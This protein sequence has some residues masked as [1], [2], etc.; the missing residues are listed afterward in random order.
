MKRKRM[1]ALSAGLLALGSG[2]LGTGARAATL[3]DALPA[4]ALVTLE[5][6]NAK[7]AFDRLLGVGADLGAIFGEEAE[8]QGALDGVR[9]VLAGSL[10]QEG[11]VGVFAVGQPGQPFMPQVLGVTRATGA[12][13]D[14]F[15]DLV[16]EKKGARVGNFTFHRQGSLFVGMA[17]GLVYFSS[18]K[19]LL[20]GYLGRLSGKDAPRLGTS[21]AYTV[22]TRLLGAPELSMYLNFSATAKVVR[23]QLARIRLP[24]LLSPLVDAL[25]TL[26][27]YAGGLTTTKEG[28]SAVSAQVVNREGKDT[29]LARMLTHQTTFSVQDIVPADAESVRASACAP[30]S[31]AYTARWL[32]RLDLFEPFGFLTDSQL[33]SHLERSGQYLGDECAQVTLAGGARAGLQLDDPLASLNSAVFYHRVRDRAAAV[34]HLPEY[35]ASVNQ[36]IAG[37]G[38]SLDR[39][40]K[41]EGGLPG[42]A[43]P[44]GLNTQAATD[45]ALS[46][47]GD[48]G[49]AVGSLKM[50][51]GFRGDYLVIAFRDAALQAALDPA[52]PA[53]GADPAFR[54]AGLPLTGAG[55]Q[56][57]RN[58]PDF[59][60]EE[61]SSAILGAAPPV[62]ERAEPA[63]RETPPEANLT[64]EEQAALDE[65][66]ALLAGG[67]TRSGGADAVTEQVGAVVSNLINRY[68]GMNMSK[69]LRGNVVLGKANVLYRW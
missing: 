31:G 30:E 32:T 21:P 62:T 53:L 41:E 18:D 24:R 9:E 51:Y 22:P 14:V 60:P 38:A 66:D 43:L 39:L 47:L 69:S 1:G 7:G 45:A 63:P 68:D 46:G 59:S 4:G 33:A 17:Q 36:A 15:A 13:A 61:F 56:F 26:G 20:M 34:A 37:L 52:R 67:G 8:V 48:V 54:A 64:P 35:A 6:Q 29:P 44:G 58:L 27:Q 57:G 55:W 19:A 42:A 11:T 28:L 5:T 3:A 2:A 49:K 23:S 25:D 10:A 16:G 40:I 65:L 12:A 50:V